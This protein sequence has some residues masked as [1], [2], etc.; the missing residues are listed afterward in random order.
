MEG[1]FYI[2][3]VCYDATWVG[4]LELE[5]SI[6]WHCVKSGVCGSSEQRMIAAAKGDDIED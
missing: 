1:V 4:H 3:I 5:I 2:S 6:V